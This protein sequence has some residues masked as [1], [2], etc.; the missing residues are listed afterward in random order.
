MRQNREAFQAFLKSGPS[1]KSGVMGVI[2][3]MSNQ[4]NNL[5]RHTAKNDSVT[6]VMEN[7]GLFHA[8]SD[9]D[10]RQAMAEIEGGIPALYS[11]GFARMQ[12]TPPS[13]LS[14]PRWLQ[15]VD[16]AGRFLDA[17]GHQAQAM[18]WRAEDLF[19]CGG[20]IQTLQGAHVT[21]ITPTSAVLSDG[22]TFKRNV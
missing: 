20:V 1:R 13:G 12:L 2:G 3:V 10:E 5:A 14:V 16:D 11:A 9:V 15:A 8:S 6:G 22:R 4:I 19:R 21:N 18:G 7:A 17:F